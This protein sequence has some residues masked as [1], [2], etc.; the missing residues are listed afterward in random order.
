M[1]VLF[2]GIIR[3]ARKKIKLKDKNLLKIIIKMNLHF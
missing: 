3:I 1:L 2:N